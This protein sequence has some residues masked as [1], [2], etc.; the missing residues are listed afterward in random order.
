[1]PHLLSFLSRSTCQPY[2]ACITLWKRRPLSYSDCSVMHKH[3]GRWV[4][5]T[6]PPGSIS[7]R[8]L[9][10]G[11]RRINADPSTNIKD[12]P[13]WLIKQTAEQTVTQRLR[14]LTLQT[15]HRGKQVKTQKHRNIWG[16]NVWEL[17]YANTCRHCS[18]V[19]QPNRDAVF[20]HLWSG[21]LLFFFSTDVICYAKESHGIQQLGWVKSNDC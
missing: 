14:E 17:G 6:S 10:R 1:M 5:Q 8:G 9:V 7:E 2:A 19:P 15:Q 21:A 18:L 16:V 12:K 11:G 13:T 3:A 4:A 20:C